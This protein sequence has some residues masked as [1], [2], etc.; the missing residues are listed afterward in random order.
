MA[1][2]TP[3]PDYVVN[4]CSEL[5]QQKET[6]CP[7]QKS[8]LTVTKNVV[9]DFNFEDLQFTGDDAIPASDLFKVS[10]RLLLDWS[11]S[12]HVTTYSN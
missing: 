8:P 5:E 4:L 1:S 2:P 3:S 12:L 6:V 11:F 9:T 10:Q 7:P